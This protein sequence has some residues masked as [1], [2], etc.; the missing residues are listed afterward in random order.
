MHAFHTVMS[1]ELV[2][3]GHERTT[4]LCLVCCW[5]TRRSDA[6]GDDV[7][8]PFE[9]LDCPLQ[10]SDPERC[11]RR[12][13]EEPNSGCQIRLG[14]CYH[15][16]VRCE[17]L[18]Q[19]SIV[20]N[21]KAALWPNAELPQNHEDAVDVDDD[22]SVE[23]GLVKANTEELLGGVEN[24]GCGHRGLPNHLDDYQI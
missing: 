12:I 2:N 7:Q 4:S 3:I 19:R 16:D 20:L 17:R 1:E 18:P 9:F 6:L 13:E 21:D 22:L 14:C 10:S 5:V 24:A 23:L 8:S 11:L 15:H